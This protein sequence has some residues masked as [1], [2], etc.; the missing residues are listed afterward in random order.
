M[1]DSKQVRNV[2]GAMTDGAN[3]GLLIDEGMFMNPNQTLV[4]A[5]PLDRR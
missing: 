3:A 1:G 4:G 5:L 2:R